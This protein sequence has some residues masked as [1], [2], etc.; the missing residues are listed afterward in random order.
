VTP[1]L[2]RLVALQEVDSDLQR[3]HEALEL[4]PRREEETAARARR[5]RQALEGQRE[6]LKHLALERREGEKLVESL[7]DQERKFQGKTAGVRTNEELWALQKEIRAVREQRSE[8]ETL[9]LE[10]MDREDIERAKLPTLERDLAEAET[11]HAEALAALAVERAELESRQAARRADR[12]RQVAELPPALKA[13]YERVLAAGRR[14][15]VVALVKNAC[16]G[17]FTAQPPQRAQE[18]R[19]GEF[20]V[21]CEFCGRLL[22][23][24]G[25]DS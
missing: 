9:V 5:A 12:E 7:A 23:G 18:V 1:E 10:A 20:V 4:L 15:A 6:A 19:R 13:R 11:R 8:R 25:G 17:C 3:L 24:T 2:A 21:V 16:G 22:V 14:P